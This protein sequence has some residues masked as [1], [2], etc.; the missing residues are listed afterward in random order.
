MDEN[1]AKV[2]TAAVVLKR[3]FVFMINPMLICLKRGEIEK[4]NWVLAIKN[5]VV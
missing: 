3:I 4:N 5:Y 1:A 2:T